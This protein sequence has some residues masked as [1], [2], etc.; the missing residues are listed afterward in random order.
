MSLTK[1]AL[2]IH[3]TSVEKR[4]WPT[5]VDASDLNRFAAK[6]A[7]VHSEVTEVLEAMRKSKGS[8]QIVD[9]VADIIIRSLDWYA[10]ALASGLVS[11][12][13]DIALREKIET[14]KSRLPKH[15][16]VWG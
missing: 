1:L 16:H 12:D 10:A 8:E 5:H 6:L 15:G 3:S 2:E 11:H 4:F 9:E 13:L 14:N 7:L